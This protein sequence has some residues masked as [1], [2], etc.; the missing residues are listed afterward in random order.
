MRVTSSTERAPRS[1]VRTVLLSTIPI[2]VILLVLAGFLVAAYLPVGTVTDC[3]VT[4]HD[5]EPGGKGFDTLIVESTCGD[6]HTDLP[7]SAF[8]TGDAYAFEL[9]GMIKPNI[10]G[11]TRTG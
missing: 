5:I 10:V 9:R 2:T 11:A 3:I 7:K 8:E 1:G 6:F 4:G